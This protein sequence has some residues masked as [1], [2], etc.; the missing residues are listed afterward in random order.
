MERSAHTLRIVIASIIAIVMVGGAYALSGPL[1]FGNIAGA[2]SAEELLREYAVLDSDFDGLPDWQ[3]ALYGTDPHN[4]ESFQAGILD[5]DAVA[6]GLIQPKISMRAED[7]LTDIDSIPGVAAAPSSLTDRFA[8]LLLTQFLQT[9]GNEALSQDE[10]ATFVTGGVQ[11]LIQTADAPARYT[12]NDILTNATSGT[13]AL[14]AYIAAIESVFARHTVA[15]EK[16]ELFYFSDA[17]RGDTAAIAKIASI[18][19]AYDNIATGMVQVRVPQEVAQAHLNVANA[20]VQLSESATYMASLETDP[21]QA[22]LGISLYETRAKELVAA[23]SHLN[24]VF[25][26]YQVS[27]PEGAPGYS[28][29]K[30]ARDAAA[31]SQ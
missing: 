30:S 22:F 1:P 3:E 28:I 27:I 18:G 19:R 7:E 2:Q 31:V 8:Q 17:L 24:S 10:V 13:E 20:L 23:F 21:L 4:P 5:G 11:S 16:S 15:A 25:S 6:R 9:R 14:V 26:A 12:A 29:L